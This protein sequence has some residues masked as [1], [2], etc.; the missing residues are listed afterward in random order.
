MEE[1]AFM[2]QFQSS[3]FYCMG[4]NCPYYPH[5]LYINALEAPIFKFF[6]QSLLIVAILAIQKLQ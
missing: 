5:Y 6:L 3:E 1:C 2:D 4:T